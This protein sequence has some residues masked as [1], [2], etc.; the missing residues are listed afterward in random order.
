MAMKNPHRKRAINDPLVLHEYRKMRG[1]TGGVVGE[2]AR[3]SLDLARARAEYKR[4]DDVEIEWIPEQESYESV[5]G[6]KPPP[7]TEF[8]GVLVKIKGRVMAS[9]G[10]VD[11]SNKEYMRIVENELLAEAFTKEKGARKNPGRATAATSTGDAVAAHELTLFAINES[12][13]YRQR[14]VPVINNLRKKVKK[15][16]YRADLALKLWRYVADDAAK[17]YTHGGYGTGKGY[18]IFT[19][20]IREATAKELAE[21]YDENLRGDTWTGNPKQRKIMNPKQR[22]RSAAQHAATRKLVA[23]N[24]RR[25]RGSIH[26][27]TRRGSSAFRGLP[28]RLLEKRGSTWR[29]AA[30]FQGTPRGI[31]R[32]KAYARKYASFER[33]QVRLIR[34]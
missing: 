6:E 1:R 13:L 24:R 16:V 23:M 33:V 21:Y 34:A 8:Y 29:T 3:R 12:E 31:K 2:D 14:I 27:K 18:G 11:D 22:R 5:Y 9:L 7:D 15:G 19:V 17:R 32:A 30:A 26:R 28:I 20:P 25:R 4:R 10:F